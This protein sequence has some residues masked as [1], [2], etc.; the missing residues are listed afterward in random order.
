MLRPRLHRIA[1]AVFAVFAASVFAAQDPRP[2][3]QTLTPE[4]KQRLG[5]A[6]LAPAQLAELDAAIGAYTRGETTVAVQQAV[7]QVEKQA[8]VRV[9]QAEKQAEAR[10]QEAK[11]AAAETAVAE[12]KKKEEPGVVARTLEVFKRKPAD[13]PHESFK[14]RVVGPFRGWTGGTYFPLEN[15]QVWRQTGGEVYDMPTVQNAEVEITKSGNGYYRL[16]YNGEWIT[17]KRLQ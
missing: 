6:E 9:Q 1:L 7:Q 15:G 11:K 5:L 3:S 2:F 16:K 10:V 17:V 8:E 14:A 4:Q 12:Y 13:E